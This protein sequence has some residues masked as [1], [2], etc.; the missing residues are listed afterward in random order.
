M[1]SEAARSRRIG[2]ALF[3]V[4]LGARWLSWERTAVLFNDGPRFLRQAEQLLQGQWAAAL[5]EPYH[6]LYAAASASVAALGFELETASAAVSIAAGSVAVV[7][8]YRF[9]RDAF[10]EPY[11]WLGAA[12]F[13]LHPRAIQFSADVQSE[14]LYFLLFLAAVMLAWRAF[15]RGS[16]AYAS[17]AGAA[18]A[19]A[20]WTRPEGLAVVVVAGALAPWWARRNAWGRRQLL[21]WGAALACPA[22]LGVA[23][24]AGALHAATGAWQVTQKKTVA[25]SEAASTPNRGP[26]TAPDAIR[27]LRPRQPKA[28]GAAL[29]DLWYTARSAA[30]PVVLVGWVVALVRLR[31]WPGPRGIWLFS[32]AL[33]YG[34]LLM[35]LLL[36]AGYVSR[37]HIL[38]P[39]LPLFGYASIGLVVLWRGAA[40]RARVLRRLAHPAPLLVGAMLAIPLLVPPRR[41]EKLA[42]REAAEWLALQPRRMATESVAG[43][44]GRVGYYAGRPMV[45]FRGFHP[46]ELPDALEAERVEFAISDRADWIEALQED[47]RFEPIHES[48][49]GGSRALVFARRARTAPPSNVND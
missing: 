17:G 1:Q 26:S 38:P 15:E 43:I 32:L 9:L 11:D 27:T 3:V 13:A 23:A 35:W 37:R 34:A 2:G 16:A 28:L 33:S 18:G 47:P 14:G 5:A 40:D 42:E 49:A 30:R 25:L 21:G 48:L 39:L 10:G 12:L 41:I 29:D 6:P 19:L 36:T 22:L 20:F 4:A 31:G 7:L 46:S 44:G 24:Y 45:D 8:L